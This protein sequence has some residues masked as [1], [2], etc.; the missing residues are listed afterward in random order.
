MIKTANID[1]EK[2]NNRATL[3]IFFKE[4]FR[5]KD[6]KVVKEVLKD[7]EGYIDEIKISEEV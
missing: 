5:A 6:L 1:I 7:L 3:K 2:Q 4:D